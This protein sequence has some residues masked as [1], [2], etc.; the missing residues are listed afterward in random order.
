LVYVLNGLGIATGVDLNA[1]VQASAFI[2]PLV[3]HPLASR[4]YQAT[5]ASVQKQ[6]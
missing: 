4:Y 2:E 5:M 1:L 6:P 3:G